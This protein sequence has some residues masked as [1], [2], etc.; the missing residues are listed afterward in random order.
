M[1]QRLFGRKTEDRSI[2][3]QEA[4]D[5]IRALEKHGAVP[6]NLSVT[7]H[8]CGKIVEKNP[9]Y[10]QVL[11][12]VNLIT[13]YTHPND[14]QTRNDIEGRYRRRDFGTYVTHR[15][16]LQEICFNVWSPNGHKGHKGTFKF[17]SYNRY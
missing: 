13:P 6:T 17:R 5:M 10:E 14:P 4:I 16:D 8:S 7:Q 9:N 1:F 11:D 15:I 12:D 3:Y 2:G